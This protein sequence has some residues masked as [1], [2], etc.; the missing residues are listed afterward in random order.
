MEN[1]STVREKFKTPEEEL[2][3]L[4]AE[5]ERRERELKE[6]GLESSRE[7]LSQEEVRHYRETP[8]EAVLHESHHLPEAEAEGLALGLAP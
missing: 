5:V 2:N 7:R 1:R 6:K 3:F 8:P 4:R